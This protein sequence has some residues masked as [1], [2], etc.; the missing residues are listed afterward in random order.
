MKLYFP[1]PPFPNPDRNEPID[2]TPQVIIFC[3]GIAIGG[4]VGSGFEKPTHLFTPQY[5][6][7]LGM[8]LIG[9]LLGIAS[10]IMNKA[11]IPDMHGMRIGGFFIAGGIIGA[12]GLSCIRYF[13]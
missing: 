5:A 13:L 3:A 7:F 8:A 6:L 9:L 10:T 2:W 12:I 11:G 4:I 1:D